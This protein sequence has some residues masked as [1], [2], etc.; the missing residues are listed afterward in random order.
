MSSI[1]DLKAECERRGF[2]RYEHLQYAQLTSLLRRGYHY[3]TP[4]R[5]FREACDHVHP[6][7]SCTSCGRGVKPEHFDFALH[8]IRM[9][10]TGWNEPRGHVVQGIDLEGRFGSMFVKKCV[11]QWDGLTLPYM[12][13]M[14]FEVLRPKMDEEVPG[15]AMHF[16]LTATPVNGGWFVPAD[17]LPEFIEFANSKNV[18]PP[19]PLREL[20]ANVVTSRRMDPAK[21]WQ[22]QRLLHY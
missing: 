1:A 19:R 17:R 12:T 8:V 3:I 7:K 6:E 14:E 13:D 5:P 10:P 2:V 16:L 11:E 20:A 21:A 9:T 18:R 22:V 4:K 15:S